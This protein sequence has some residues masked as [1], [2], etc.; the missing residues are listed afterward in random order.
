MTLLKDMPN[1]TEEKARWNGLLEQLSPEEI[2]HWA[3]ESF[4]H[5]LAMTSAFGINGVTLIAMLQAYTREV[6]I[7]F[8]D[9][10]HHFEE[11]LHTKRAIEDAYSVPVL[12]IH[13]L[14][15]N[16][17]EEPDLYLRQPDL[18]C[19]LRKVE[20]MQR[21]LA[22]LRPAALLNGRSRFQ[23]AGRRNLPI[24]EWEKEPICINPLAT[25]SPSQIEAYVQQHAVPHNPLHDA[26]YPSIGCRP[27]TRPIRRGEHLRAGR[28]SGHKK[29]ECGLWTAKSPAT[30]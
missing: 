18:C 26:G 20:P 4:G 28:W 11:T 3:V 15:G 5:G 6:P 25:W 7:L 13:P 27:C 29:V 21:A 22:A 10:G 12:V 9:T 2:L 23:S 14:Q 19:R 24:V 30:V 1:T 17:Q 8:V 16:V